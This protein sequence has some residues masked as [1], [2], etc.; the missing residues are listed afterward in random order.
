ME[1]RIITSLKHDFY[2]WCGM[3]SIDECVSNERLI[4]L[5]EQLER[6]ILTAEHGGK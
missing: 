1:E 2:D 4:K 5:I 3:L 6:L